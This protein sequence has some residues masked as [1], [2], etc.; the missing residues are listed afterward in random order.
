MKRYAFV[1][2]ALVGLVA[3]LCAEGFDCATEAVAEEVVQANIANWRM[4]HPELEAKAQGLAASAAP[5][6]IPMKIAYDSAAAA[7]MGGEAG[8]ENWAR[9][10]VVYLNNAEANSGTTTRY[11]LIG[12]KLIENPLDQATAGGGAL[13]AWGHGDPTLRAFRAGASLVHYYSGKVGGGLA[14]FFD[15]TP[16]HFLSVSGVEHRTM[17]HEIGHNLGRRHDP[18]T[19]PGGYYDGWYFQGVSGRW[20]QDIMSYDMCPTGHGCD[21][22]LDLF[23]TPDVIRDGKPVGVAGIAEAANAVIERA[24]IVAS[25][26]TGNDTAAVCVEDEYTLCLAGFAVA[27]Y[28]K[29]ADGSRQGW[30]HVVRLT[31]NSGYLWFFDPTNVELTVKVLDACSYNQRFWFFESGMTSVEVQTFV[32]DVAHPANKLSR[33]NT[34]GK[35]FVTQADTATLTCN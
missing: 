9:S 10:E 25:F 16:E 15:G 7:R 18:T 14:D 11:L 31:G 4:E 30:A 20:Y 8:F 27:A 32:M 5:V 24:P 13:K 3:P 33:V 35:L 17:A 2:I 29:T 12:M 22:V 21:E 23:A 19:D 34:Q 1:L 6:V 26:A 28:Y